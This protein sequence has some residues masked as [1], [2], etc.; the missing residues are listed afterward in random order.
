MMAALLLLKVVDFE[1][2]DDDGSKMCVVQ[3]RQANI[4]G[5]IEAQRVQSVFVFAFLTHTFTVLCMNT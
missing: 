1:K 5:R 4:N 2:D 3:V